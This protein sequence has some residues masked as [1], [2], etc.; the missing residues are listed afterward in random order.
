MTKIA[1]IDRIKDWPTFFKVIRERPA[2]W[3]G[4]V[5]VSNFWNLIGGI[6]LA[7]YFYKIP[8]QDSFGNFNFDEFEKWVDEKYNHKRLSL[9]SFSLAK[10]LSENEEDGFWKWYEWY[11]LFSKSN[12]A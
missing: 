3:I 12:R 1:P 8:E 11:D 6:Q 5:S 4:E 9:N 2:M 10:E 7:E